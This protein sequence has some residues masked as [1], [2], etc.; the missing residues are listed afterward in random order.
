MFVPLIVIQELQHPSAPE[1]VRRWAD[2]T[3]E[4]LEIRAAGP[5]T[6]PA[7]HRIDPGEREAIQLAISLHADTV[8]IDEARGRRVAKSLH[9]EVRG[10]LGILERAAKL[11]KIH[12]RTALYKLEQSKFRIS[13]AVWEEFL[14]RNP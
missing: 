5:I 8:L 14:R 10:T 4:W 1:R 3:P 9:L 13:S 7:L 11:G 12:F 6:I 2:K